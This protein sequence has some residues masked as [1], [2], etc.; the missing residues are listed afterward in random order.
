LTFKEV[1]GER[2]PVVLREVAKSDCSNYA[3]RTASLP[4]SIVKALAQQLDA[5]VGTVATEASTTTVKAAK[6]RQCPGRPTLPALPPNVANQ[7]CRESRLAK[8]ISGNPD[9]F[10]AAV[11]I[12]DQQFGNSSRTIYSI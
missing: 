10:A 9:Y 1:A 8:H 11:L 7:I 12:P 5:E 2:S 3:V 6:D 4:A